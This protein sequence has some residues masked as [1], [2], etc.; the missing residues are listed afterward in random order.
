MKSKSNITTHSQ[1]L[2]TKLILFIMSFLEDHKV[3]DIILIDLFKKSTMSDCLIIGSGRS[4]KHVRMS[5]EILQLELAKQGY[6]KIIVE[7][8]PSSE[9]V[10]LDVGSA[11]VHLFTPEMR[12]FYNLEKMWGS[13]FR[14]SNHQEEKIGA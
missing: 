8:L 11:I 14:P 10:L 4:Q 2:D 3:E 5:I 9:W 1:V 12:G 13:D 6:K 7:G